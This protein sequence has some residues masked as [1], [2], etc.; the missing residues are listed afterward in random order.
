VSTG[1]A[2]VAQGGKGLGGGFG[3]DDFGAFGGQSK[4]GTKSKGKGQTAPKGGADFGGAGQAQLI[5]P[6]FEVNNLR[7]QIVQTLGKIGPEAKDAVP[8]LVAALGL[9][10][11][12]NLRNAIVQTLGEMGP[13]AKD[14]VPVL[15]QMCDFKDR[16]F[17]PNF[18]VNAIDALANIG[19]AAKEA[20]PS[21][22]ALLSGKA[23]VGAPSRRHIVI[24]L[25]NIGPE[26]KEAVPRLQQIIDGELSSGLSGPAQLQLQAEA[27]KALKKIQQN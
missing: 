15:I 5:A 6:A 23:P 4:Q 2:N 12:Q 9:Y 3:D 27:A 16:S 20:V 19:P 25:G 22:L 24:A 18:V 13:G 26:A 14:T 8:T 10:D 1:Q 7:M 11:D 17:Q 21:L